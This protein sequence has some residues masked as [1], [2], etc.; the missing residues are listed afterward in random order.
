MHQSHFQVGVPQH[1]T[2][3]LVGFGVYGYGGLGGLTAAC[4]Q[5]PY[6]AALLGRIVRH[7]FPEATYTTVMILQDVILSTIHKDRNNAA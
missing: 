2:A 7:H 5:L 4:R 1:D 6:T 3:A